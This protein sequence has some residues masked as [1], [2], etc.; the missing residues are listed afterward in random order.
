M[1][2]GTGFVEARGA[3]GFM[4]GFGSQGGGVQ[5]TPSR[6]GSVAA[7][8]KT[9]ATAGSPPVTPASQIIP[10]FSSM[11]LEAAD[12]KEDDE[13]TLNYL[14]APTIRLDD[15]HVD[16]TQENRDTNREAATQK[17]TADVQSINSTPYQPDN[18]LGLSGA[19]SPWPQ[20]SECP[21]PSSPKVDD[22]AK[23][24]VPPSVSLAA[25]PSVA[26]SPAA[27]PSSSAADPSMGGG[28]AQQQSQGSGPGVRGETKKNKYTDGSYWKLLESIWYTQSWL[29]FLLTCDQLFP[30]LLGYE[31]FAST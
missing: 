24:P 22:K 14:R 1:I 18:Q 17:D 25:T 19:E 6:D 4:P 12:T 29:Y 9:P 10:S 31:A 26:A 5:V 28:V 8:P 11:S 20:D 16:T 30:C 7:T 15:T 13:K 3:G 27:S 2:P 23:I 21:E